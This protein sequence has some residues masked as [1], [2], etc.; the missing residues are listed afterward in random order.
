MVAQ[1]HYWRVT[2]ADFEKAAAQ[3]EGAVHKAV[4]SAAVSETRDQSPD[5]E[6][7]A[8]CINSGE[9]KVKKYTPQES[10]L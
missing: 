10:N 5:A 6:F 1:K 3:P 8:M 9:F 7:A 2:E 4:Q